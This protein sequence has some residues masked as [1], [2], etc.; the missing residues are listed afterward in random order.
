MCH[1]RACRYAVGRIDGVSYATRNDAY[2]W[3]RGKVQAQVLYFVSDLLSVTLLQVDSFSSRV[4]D[5]KR[6]LGDLLMV[7][8]AW[9]A[10]H[11]SLQ[12]YT[13]LLY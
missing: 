12:N 3:N 9:N 11:C 6:L 4:G 13:A 7:V 2:Q 1:P 8:E 5:R 10:Q